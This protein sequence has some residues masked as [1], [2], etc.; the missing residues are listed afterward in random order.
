M[1]KTHKVTLREM[2]YDND[3]GFSLVV[4]TILIILVAFLWSMLEKFY[5]K[6]KTNFGEAWK[7]LRRN[8]NTQKEKTK[9]NAHN[10]DSHNNNNNRRVSALTNEYQSKQ[11]GGLLNPSFQHTYFSN[12]TQENNNS[13]G[14]NE[15]LHKME[16]DLELIKNSIGKLAGH[17]S[18]RKKSFSQFLASWRVNTGEGYS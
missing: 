14:L 12:S 11:N 10:Y 6:K 15:R 16:T 7:F 3:H 18:E 8:N 2:L 1:A 5:F 17:E 13:R 9:E 4:A